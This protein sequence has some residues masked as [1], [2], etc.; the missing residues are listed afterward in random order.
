MIPLAKAPPEEFAKLRAVL[1]DIDDTLTLRGR[2]P[3]VAFKALEDLRKAGLI[4]IPVTGRPAGWC[5]HI[6]RMWPVDAVVGENGA[7]TFRY[8]D[9]THRMIRDYAQDAET[10]HANMARLRGIARQVLMKFP[11]AAI[12]AD[13]AYREIDVA[14]DFCEDVEP[15]PLSAAV[16]IKKMFEAEGAIAKISSIHVNAWFGDHDKQSTARRLLRG[17]FKLD[18]SDAIYVGD[19]PNDAPMFAR[20]PLSV[21][22]AN[23]AQYTA[24]MDHLPR[25]VTEA[26]GGFGFAELAKAVIAAKK[27]NAR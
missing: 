17:I 21:G 16:K 26:E 5:D 14:I 22:V 1:A 8:D 24:L 23:I 27:K 12:A 13:Q 15:L 2:L 6:A 9:K 7:F 25:Y 11:G 10:R 19:S 20:F 3:A 18:P 4:V